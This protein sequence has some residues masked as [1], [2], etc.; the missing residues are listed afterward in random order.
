MLGFMFTTMFI[1]MWISNTATTAMMIPIVNAVVKAINSK[2]E[3]GDDGDD[4]EDNIDI[5]TDEETKPLISTESFES[6]LKQLTNGKINNIDQLKSLVKLDDGCGHFEDLET[7][8]K[9]EPAI[10]DSDKVMKTE[11]NGNVFLRSGKMKRLRNQQSVIKE[12]RQNEKLAEVTRTS[13]R[14]SERE[15]GETEEDDNDES[16]V[17]RNYLLLGLAMSSNIGGTG[18]VTGTPPNLVAPDVLRKYGEGTSGLTFASWMAFAIPV[19]LVNLLL[20]WLWLQQLM[21]WTLGKRS[22]Q[23]KKVGEGWIIFILVIHFY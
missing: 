17:Q 20:A 9:K 21:A 6:E 22:S 7:I 18:V 1:S 16:E 2:E 3:D 5:I 4:G 14:E 8:T 13:Q 10:T 23:N 12:I 15:D 19:M 11:N